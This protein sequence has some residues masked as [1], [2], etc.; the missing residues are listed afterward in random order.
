MRK[1]STRLKT[2]MALACVALLLAGCG[3][4][5][6]G[7]AVSPV[8]DPFRVG[9]LPAED[10][11]SGVRPDAPD[12]Q[13]EVEYTDGGSV[14]KMAAQA[15]DDVAEYW[16]Q[17]YGDLGGSF[18]PIEVLQ[19][20]DATDPNSPEI[21]GMETYDVPNALYCIPDE[22]MAWD[23]GVLV[24]TG[25][26]YFGDVSVAALL[27]HEYGHA[28]QHM[29]NIVDKSTPTVVSE[30]QADCFAG[31]YIRW[32]AEG[33]SPRFKLSTGDGLNHVLAAAITLRDPTMGPGDTAML[34]EGHGTALDRVSAFQIGFSGSPAECA[35]IDMD[36]IQERRGDLPME[37]PLD[38]SGGVATGDLEITED[39]LQTLMKVLTDIY[40]PEEEPT[41]SFNEEECS[42]ATSS[43]PASYCPS[44]NTISV[45]L[46]A[47]QELGKPG[48]LENNVL[49]QGDNTALS[50][51]TSRYALAVQ[52]E[53]GETL[54]TPVAALR[55]ACLTGVAQAAMSKEGDL[56]LSAGDLDEAVA[57]LLTNGLVASNVNGDTVPAGFTRI[58]AFRSG[59][60]GDQD[61]CSKRFK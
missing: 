33:K 30:Q 28:V 4:V 1:R 21:C 23:R 26:K 27:G 18:Q 53:K 41:L 8:Y 43:P 45:D 22:S 40:Q 5:T 55:T 44:T 52:H 61:L 49:I 9:G 35:A 60:G 14:D 58:V 51:L 17:N 46:S 50:V 7:Q 42:D 34:E 24:P 12:P 54:D 20:W 10:G 31:N 15:V 32:V 37:L 6:R 3:G 2:S 11:D 56:T 36:E 13:H 39:S 57:G 47:M 59:L 29:A 38:S 48:G 25:M 19:S 16:E